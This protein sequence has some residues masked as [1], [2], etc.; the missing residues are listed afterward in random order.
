[1]PIDGVQIATLAP[2]SATISADGGYYTACLPPGEPATLQFSMPGYVTAYLAELNLTMELPFGA[3]NVGMASML[4]SSAEQNF[5]T[6]VTGFDSDDAIVFSELLSISNIPPCGGVDGGLAGWIFAAAPADGGMYDAGSWEVA[7]ID[8]SGTLESI[9]STLDD[10][11]AVMF[12]IDPSVQYVTVTASKAAVGNLC[13][14]LNAAAHLTGRV[15][16]APHS[17]SVIPWVMP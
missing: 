11:E 9:G 6:E 2:Y 13:P 8:A 7:Y 5:A 3:N 1:V 10:G 12:N 4:C 17:F 14:T 16:V 15:Y